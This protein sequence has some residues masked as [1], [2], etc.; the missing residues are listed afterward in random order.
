[1]GYWRGKP[2]PLYKADKEMGCWPV[3]AFLVALA[4]ALVASRLLG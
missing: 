3:V 4:V 2:G 1:M